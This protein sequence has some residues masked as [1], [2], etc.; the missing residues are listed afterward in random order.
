M[1]ESG[2]ASHIF[3]IDWADTLNEI[4]PVSKIKKVFFIFTTSLVESNI[5][6]IIIYRPDRY[7]SAEPYLRNAVFLYRNMYISESTV[8]ELARPLPLTRCHEYRKKIIHPCRGTTTFIERC[9]I[10][11]LIIAHRIK[12]PQPVCE[13]F[14]LADSLNFIGT[15]PVKAGLI[16]KPQGI[17]PLKA[18]FYFVEFNALEGLVDIEDRN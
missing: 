7:R 6:K 13:S 9:T 1:T 2:I 11:F 14:H 8:S 12:F 10:L 17:D 18:Q 3:L 5:F 15:G 16:E 4:S